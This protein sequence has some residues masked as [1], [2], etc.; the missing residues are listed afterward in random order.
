MRK[1]KMMVTQKWQCAQLCL[2]EEPPRIERTTKRGNLAP[3]YASID[4]S[5]PLRFP[6]LRMHARHLS[7]S[8]KPPQIIKNEK[9]DATKKTN[10]DHHSRHPPRTI[11]AVFLYF[12]TATTPPSP[13]TQMNS[14]SKTCAAHLF[15]TFSPPV[16]QVGGRSGFYKTQNRNFFVC[17]LE[18]KTTRS[19]SSRYGLRR[20]LRA[21]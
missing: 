14:P 19:L 18:Q 8:T 21:Q 4:N 2:A 13:L 15:P 5:A 11:K 10:S 3:R 20:L 6:R 12:S 17:T 1:A 7:H 16:R 9:P